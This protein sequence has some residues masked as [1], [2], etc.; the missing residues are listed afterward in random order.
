MMQ[1]GKAAEEHRR[2]CEAR[3]V[4]AWPFKQR[5]PYLELV[6]KRRGDAAR[7]EL[8]MEVMRQHRQA[9]VRA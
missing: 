7:K 4:L 5:K 3:Q 1:Q 2:A 6:G 8:E 9:K